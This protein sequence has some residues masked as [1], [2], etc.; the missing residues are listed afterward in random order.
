MVPQMVLWKSWRNS[1]A[2][3]MGTWSTLPRIW[4]GALG[5]SINW[6]KVWQSPKYASG[7]NKMAQQLEQPT[8]HCYCWLYPSA[9]L[10]HKQQWHLLRIACFYIDFKTIDRTEALDITVSAT[11]EETLKYCCVCRSSCREV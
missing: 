3:N 7:R 5:V 1:V 10:L 9:V 4:G 2:P 6:L 8:G 11:R